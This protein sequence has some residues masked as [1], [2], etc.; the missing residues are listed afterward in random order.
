MTC[1][2]IFF[3][4]CIVPKHLIC[5]GVEIYRR[6]VQV[7]ILLFRH[8]DTSFSLCKIRCSKTWQYWIREKPVF[9]TWKLKKKKILKII[10]CTIH[11]LLKPVSSK[12]KKKQLMHIKNRFYILGYIGKKLVQRTS[13]NAYFIEYDLFYYLPLLKY[14]FTLGIRISIIL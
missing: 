9:L 14:I 4:Y 3:S 1:I 5:V 8:K 6:L 12:K 2:M 11:T 10:H 13:F 7:C